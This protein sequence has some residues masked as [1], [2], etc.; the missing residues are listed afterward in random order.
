MIT[1][2]SLLLNFAV[3]NAGAPG[4]S[5]VLTAPQLNF[6]LRSQDGGIMYPCT[7]KAANPY[8]SDWTVACGNADG[9]FR[10]YGVHLL[11]NVYTSPTP[12]KVKYEVLYWVTARELPLGRGRY[13]GSTTWFRLNEPSTLE[14]LSLA[15]DV[16]EIWSL[17]A[18]IKLN[19][20]TRA[21]S[22]GDRRHPAGGLR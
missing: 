8:G 12:P 17:E 2:F 7:F 16:E 13:V 22:P 5:A 18:E 19:A 3:A 4:L 6:K 14:S 11:V 15:Q 1:I 9:V 21:I 10:N 20:A